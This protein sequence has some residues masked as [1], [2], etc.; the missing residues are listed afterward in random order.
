MQSATPSQLGLP[1]TG[2]LQDSLAG[3]AILI[4]G[5]TAFVALCAHISASA[6][7]HTG[8]AYAPELR[9]PAGRNVPRTGRRIHRHGSL[10]ARGRNRSSGLHPLLRRR[11]CPPAWPKRRFPLLLP[12]C[13]SNCRLDRAHLSAS[14]LQVPRSAACRC[15]RHPAHLPFWSRLVCLCTLTTVSRPHGRSPSLRSSQARSLKSQP[16]QAFS[17]AFSDGEDTKK[18]LNQIFPPRASG[19][20]VS[21]AHLIIFTS[22]KD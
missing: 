3:K 6:S 2:S 10:S 8:S 9:G 16:P 15:R 12:P 19:R 7:L 13:S 21:S 11:R 17:A 1:H 20:C 22:Q 4:V 5:A 14:N 18:T